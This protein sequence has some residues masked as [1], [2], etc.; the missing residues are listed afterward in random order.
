VRLRNI[1][2][3]LILAFAVFV[4][5][6]SAQG[7]HA[8]QVTIGPSPDAGGS[9]PQGYTLY[10]AA[11][12]AGTFSKVNAALS[13]SLVITDAGLAPGSYCYRATF[14]L[15]GAESA[16]S[17]TAV[18]NITPTSPGVLTLLIN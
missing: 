9:A 16:P 3:S 15:S 7:T 5:P 2:T 12:C 8:V 17:T 14:T 13:S 4:G 1:L 10:K 11:T 18:A 6:C